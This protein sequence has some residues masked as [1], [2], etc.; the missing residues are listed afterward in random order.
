MLSRQTCQLHTM[1]DLFYAL[2]ITPLLTDAALYDR[3][4]ASVSPDRRERLG[5][6]RSDRERCLSL[7]GVLLLRYALRER[8]A[9]EPEIA[10]GPHGKPYCADR[11][12]VHFNVSHSGDWAVCAV[13]SAPV[14][15]DIERIGHYRPRV[16]ERCFA[17][18]EL[19]ALNALS[20][21]AA[22]ADLFFRFW[23]LKESFL[24]ALGCGISEPLSSVSFDLSGEALRVTQ[25]LSDKQ[26]A[27][28]EYADLPGYRCTLCRAS[29]AP[30]PPLTILPITALL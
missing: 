6:I 25:A 9:G 28:R 11:P 24:K 5:R 7:G 12:D 16:A 4:F 29:A 8:G 1:E 17:P 22:Q 3:A 13:S 15:C 2:N 23:T 14:G 30:V 10:Y 26:F 20:D 27:F 19:A 18:E 21:E